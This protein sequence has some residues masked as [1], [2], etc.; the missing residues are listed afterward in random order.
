MVQVANTPK[1]FFSYIF[2]I[3]DTD[4]SGRLGKRPGTGREPTGWFFRINYPRGKNGKAESEL[5]NLMIIPGVAGPV[6]GDVL[7]RGS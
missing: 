7:I 6:S 3:Y 2:V 4:R 1:N 5:S